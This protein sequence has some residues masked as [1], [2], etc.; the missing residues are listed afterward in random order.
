MVDP[1]ELHQLRKRVDAMETRLNYAIVAL[2]V[3]V[4][5]LIFGMALGF[6]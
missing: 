2:T 4:S 1:Y 6:I 5:F 3:I